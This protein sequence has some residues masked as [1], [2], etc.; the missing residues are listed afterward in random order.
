MIVS[1]PVLLAS[2][3]VPYQIGGDAAS[4]LWLLPLAAAVSLV[5][6]ALK[7]PV[8]T[9]QKF[10]REVIVLFG[11]ILFFMAII[12]IGLYAIGRIVTG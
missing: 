11:T 8:M 5:Y 10:I 3:T 12:A 7:L 9:A 6:K 4:L 1:Y 2:F